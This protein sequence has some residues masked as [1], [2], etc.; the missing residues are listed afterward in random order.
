MALRSITRHLALCSALLAWSVQAWML[1]SKDGE[2]TLVAPLDINPSYD[3]ARVAF[4]SAGQRQWSIYLDS[5]N[6][7][8]FRHRELQDYVTLSTDSLAVYNFAAFGSSVSVTSFTRLGATPSISGRTTLGSSCS[9]WDTLYLGNT[10][11]VKN[12]VRL[13]SIPPASG[14]SCLGLELLV[15]DEGHSGSSTSAGSPA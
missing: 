9:T 1:V 5:Q 11:L 7:L 6:D 3:N 2:V 4:K 15:L 12:S 10:S 8:R 13:G 14:I